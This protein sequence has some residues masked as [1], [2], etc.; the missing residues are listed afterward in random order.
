METEETAV[1]KVT[2]AESAE[3]DDDDE[4]VVVNRPLEVVKCQ[5]CELIEECTIAY[6]ARVRERNEGWWICGLCGEA[7]KEEI[8]R[9]GWRISKEEA[10]ERHAS[11]C[12]ES[13]SPPEKPTEELISALKQ[14]LMKSCFPSM[15][16]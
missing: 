16:A 3:K 8:K 15:D 4:D 10:L 1:V 7:V 13:R 5:C 11:F 12:E 9:S 14:L 2:G 6:I